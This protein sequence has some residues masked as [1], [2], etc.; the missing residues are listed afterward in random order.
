MAGEAALTGQ[1]LPWIASRH[2]LLV[3]LSMGRWGTE[4]GGR[5]QREAEE[6]RA[7]PSPHSRTGAV[8]SDTQ[9]HVRRALLLHP[10]LIT[11]VEGKNF[12]AALQQLVRLLRSSP[13]QALELAARCPGLLLLLGGHLDRA[14]TAVQS[15]CSPSPAASASA[16]A[17]VSTFPQLL[18]QSPAATSHLA[19]E[20]LATCSSSTGMPPAAA[21]ALV[22]AMIAAEPRVL[23][24]GQAASS[25]GSDSPFL[26]KLLR[27]QEV[28]SI[29]PADAW[30][31]AARCPSLLVRGAPDPAAA[32]QSALAA[33]L[34]A[35]PGSNDESASGTMTSSLELGKLAMACPNLMAMPVGSAARF[36][37]QLEAGP[38]Q[39]LPGSSVSELLSASPSLLSSCVEGVRERVVLP[40]L[41]AEI[42]AI[43]SMPLPAATGAPPL[44]QSGPAFSP[45]EA[46]LIVVRHPWLLR[47]AEEHHHG[48]HNGQQGIANAPMMQQE[49]S[50]VPLLGDASASAVMRVAEALRLPSM[51]QALQLLLLLSE[52]NQQQQ[53]P[54]PQQLPLGGF[55]LPE[56]SPPC[57][58]PLFPP[59]QALPC[60]LD[61]VKRSVD[62]IAA[63]ATWSLELQRY[64]QLD[65]KQA[66]PCAWYCITLAW[67]CITLAW[68]SP[69]LCFHSGSDGLGEPHP[70]AKREGGE[71]GVSFQT[72]GLEPQT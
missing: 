12:A 4:H 7:E 1:D 41:L 15:S 6:S 51:L 65:N 70:G 45:S 71:L 30:R 54:A 53:P 62:L 20:L 29:G 44:L 59:P 27:I 69:P 31:L 21:A 8:L 33:A 36:R 61:E 67:H 5:S 39:G 57:T 68:H 28:L 19:G 72:G 3:R 42:R 16:V 11:I 43:L 52:R 10:G 49:G 50:P 48:E 47:L 60:L 35:A 22:A 66:G 34:P 38:L 23:I 18:E 25:H 2:Q 26:D 63:D 24:S 9:Q 55:E 64:I 13:G 58:L 40:R 56:G 14:F 32:L 46:A 17:A 37:K